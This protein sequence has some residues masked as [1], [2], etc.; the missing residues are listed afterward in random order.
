LVAARLLFAIAGSKDSS[1]R[2]LIFL[3][4]EEDFEL[5]DSK[6]DMTMLEEIA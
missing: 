4:P 1:I 6:E 2:F 5:E 3:A